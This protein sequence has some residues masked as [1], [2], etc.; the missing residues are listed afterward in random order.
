MFHM[1]LLWIHIPNDNR[2]F[3]G[4][5]DNQIWEFEDVEHEWAI[6]HIKSH[7]GARANTLFEII[8]K[9]GDITWLPY[10]KISHLDALEQYFDVLGI[11][12][13]AD[14]PDGHG[15]PPK[16]NFQILLGHMD[17]IDDNSFRGLY[18]CPD[19]ALAPQHQRLPSP[20]IYLFLST[21]N[22]T[23][24]HQSAPII[25]PSF[26]NLWYDEDQQL[27]YVNDPVKNTSLIYH[28]CQVRLF[29]LFVHNLCNNIEVDTPPVGYMQFA[30][31]LKLW[32]HYLL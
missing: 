24:P 9:S 20:T 2:L 28:P 29:L 22:P 5:L 7:S 18:I 3:P 32:G 12:S 1:S 31:S 13:I 14:L 23:M 8:W 25:S 21:I 19:Y 11:E 4:W 10:H 30:W 6:E 26:K 17:L 27:I 15:K 16:N